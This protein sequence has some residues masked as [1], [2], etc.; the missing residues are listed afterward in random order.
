MTIPTI[1]SGYRLLLPKI[2]LWDANGL[3]N[4]VD[5]VAFWLARL[6]DN[7][8]MD[9]LARDRWKLVM[10]GGLQTKTGKPLSL[11][12]GIVEGHVTQAL[13]ERGVWQ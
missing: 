7:D 13:K 8:S 5:E 9:D 4:W 2:N 1:L 6:P 11:C 3:M 10:A 12:L